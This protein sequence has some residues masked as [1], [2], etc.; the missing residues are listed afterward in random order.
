MLTKENILNELKDIKEEMNKRF[1]VKNI[2]LFGSFAKGIEK[3]SSDIDFLVEFDDDAD[4]FD[5]V[6]LS[7]YLEE[8]FNTKVDVISKNALRDEQKDSIL[9][10]ILFS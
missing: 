4:L 5:F 1:K 9:K 2:G 7:I 8:K 3:K 6:G 10:S